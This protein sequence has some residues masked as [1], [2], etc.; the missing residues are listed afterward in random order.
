MVMILT[1]LRNG[2]LPVTL[3]AAFLLGAQELPGPDAP[4]ATG[5]APASEAVVTESAPPAEPPA[6]TLFAAE[7]QVPF[8]EAGAIMAIDPNL[9]TRYG[10][11]PDLPGF[12]QALLFKTPR[13]FE[14]ALTVEEHGSIVDRRIA[15]TEQQMTDLRRKCSTAATPAPVA[16]PTPTPA[17]V[18]VPPPSSTAPVT[19]AVQKRPSSFE[20]EED[21]FAPFLAYTTLW[22]AGYGLMMPYIF[23]G[24]NAHWAYYPGTSLLA[25][26]AA[27][28]LGYV[29]GRNAD[30]T[31]G[32]ALSSAEGALR[33]AV[34]GASLFWLIAG[35][36]ELEFD[37]G[38]WRNDIGLRPDTYT[39]LLLASTMLFSMGEYALGMW[40]ADHYGLTGGEARM[41]GVGSTLGY[42]VMLELALTIFM[43]LDSF[44]PP[45]I[46]VMPAMLLAG[47]AGGLF[48][49]HFANRWDH[50]TEGDASL[51]QSFSA[52]TSFFPPSIAL[53]AKT[54]DARV[55][56]GL[57]LA[58]TISGAVGGYFLLK[59]LD[60]S[61]MDAFIIGLGTAAG[62]LT[63]TGIAFLATMETKQYETLG[64]AASLG[65]LA[66]FGLMYYVYY[67]RGLRQ[68][69]EREASSW[70]LQLNPAGM[71]TALS[72]GRSVAP[73][74]EEDLRILRETPPSPVVS[75]E[76]HW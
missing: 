69:Q 44:A 40:Y 33:G 24:D 15:I 13:G 47:G 62:G 7:E 32:M 64:V 11:F 37:E 52:I 22:S 57:F 72:G 61:N 2:M 71:V 53:A 43:G 26:G 66:G 51:I 48:L 16:P 28:T 12:R 27:F 29:L 67:D 56:P 73:R 23:G 5:P 49:G 42:G 3:C 21:G 36:M 41:L 63:T 70:N 6:P 25:G 1:H 20:N 59:G 4:A 31:R 17:P 30:I 9:R 65:T 18:P 46:R 76:Y 35:S 54:D 10:L 68:A 19:V 8:D 45:V 39:R 55:Y 74:T 34:D 38:G 50:Y 60:F 75:F 58:G 14:L